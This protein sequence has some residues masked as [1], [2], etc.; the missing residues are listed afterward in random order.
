MTGSASPVPSFID[1]LH[2]NGP[3][4]DRAD[5]MALYAW[6]V[7]SWEMDVVIHRGDGTT[8]STHGFVSAGW[9][10]E[11]RA[12][13]DVFAV[14]G[15]FYGTTLRLYDPGLDAWHVLWNDPLNQVCVTMIGRSRGDEIVNEGKEPASLAR[16]YGAPPVAGSEAT[17]R[18]IFSDI[19]P[20]SFRWRSER[21][22]DGA[23]W[24]LQREYFCR[25][26]G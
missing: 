15:L 19:T 24:R 16:L 22:V 7:G 2:S 11:S 14:P 23:T 25:R 26:V 3:A 12:V 18:W 8:Q 9:V 1:A 13:Q 5:R 6:L 4:S 10:L 17:L 21:S 20:S